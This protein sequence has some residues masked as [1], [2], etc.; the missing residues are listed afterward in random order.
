M[1]ISKITIWLVVLTILKNMKVNGKDYPIY[2]MENTKC[3]KPPKSDEKMVETIVGKNKMVGCLFFVF[4]TFVHILYTIVFTKDV[5]KIPGN[6][7]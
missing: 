7:T 4:E 3:S 6:L 5:M 2:E 1:I